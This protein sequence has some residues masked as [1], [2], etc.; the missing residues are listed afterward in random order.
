[1]QRSVGPLNHRQI[2]LPLRFLVSQETF[3]TL[4]DSLYFHRRTNF[5]KMSWQ[6]YVDNL[7][8]DG[9]CQDAAI[10][11]FTDAKYVWASCGGGTFASITVST[12]YVSASWVA[13]MGNVIFICCYVCLHSQALFNGDKASTVWYTWYPVVTQDALAACHPSLSFLS[14]SRALKCVRG[15]NANVTLNWEMALQAGG[16]KI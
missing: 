2:Q 7:M 11:G 10:V 3:V 1:M 6:G 16:N 5:T 12:L 8:S 13:Q 14:H 4:L 9:S 15:T